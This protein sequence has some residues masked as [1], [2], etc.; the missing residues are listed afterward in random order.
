MECLV[1]IR[2]DLEDLLDNVSAF[3]IAEH[4]WKQRHENRLFAAQVCFCYLAPFT[5]QL[6]RFIE[7]DARTNTIECGVHFRFECLEFLVLLHEWSGDRGR[8]RIS[9]WN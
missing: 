1:F 8:L 9:G 5:D 4:L 3:R 7:R 6:H 2:T